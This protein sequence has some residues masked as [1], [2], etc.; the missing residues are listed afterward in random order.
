MA[1]HNAKVEFEI[2]STSLCQF[3]I[4]F[5][6]G[7]VINFSVCKSKVPLKWIPLAYH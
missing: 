2:E 7:Q 5:L 1:N 6:K 4:M 3:P